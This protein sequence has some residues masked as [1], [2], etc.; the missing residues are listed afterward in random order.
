MQDAGRQGDEQT[1]G[2]DDLDE[3]HAHSS[4]LIRSATGRDTA[5]G[6]GQCNLRSSRPGARRPPWNTAC[7]SALGRRVLANRSFPRTGILR[8]LQKL[9]S[10]LSRRWDAGARLADASAKG[11]LRGTLAL[12]KP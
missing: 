7:L 10:G 5:H 3:P 11:G 6:T 12:V 1:D 9:L 8:L 4:V 2:D